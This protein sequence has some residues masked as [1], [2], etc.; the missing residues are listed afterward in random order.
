MALVTAKRSTSTKASTAA[1]DPISQRLLL[2]QRRA[3]RH[4]ASGQEMHETKGMNVEFAM[5]KQEG[6]E[7]LVSSVEETAVS[8]QQDIQKK[9]K[10]PSARLNLCRR[11]V[12]SALLGA[13]TILV[14]AIASAGPAPR[15]EVRVPRI[16]GRVIE[17]LQRWASEE[18]ES[19]CEEA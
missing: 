10:I 12:A 18:E 3:S 8:V 15:R 2:P 4:P 5:P 14:P 7:Q 19:W 17:N 1:L 9:T 16:D 11:I 6:F 13:L